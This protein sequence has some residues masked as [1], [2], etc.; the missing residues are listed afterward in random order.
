MAVKRLVVPSLPRHVESTAPDAGYTQSPRAMEWVARRLREPVDLDDGPGVGRRLY[1]SRAGQP[2]RRVVNEDALQPTFSDYDFELVH[3]EAWSLSE[4]VAAFSRADAVCGPHG[5]GLINLVYAGTDVRV[6]ELFGRRTN[7]CF[8]G[9][10]DGMGKP[11]AAHHATPAGE[12]LRVDPEN[13][14]RLLAM[15]DE[16]PQ[17]SSD[18]K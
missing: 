11:Y 15:A 16:W 9:I 17:A 18:S 10:A 6:L 4:Q 3:P 13:L 2:A 8:Y 12:H 14:D 7:P 5:A 1:V